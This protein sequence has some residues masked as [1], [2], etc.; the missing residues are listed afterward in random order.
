MEKLGQYYL[1]AHLQ[2][3]KVE[4]MENLGQYLGQYYLRAHLQY[5]KVKEMENLGQYWENF[6]VLQAVN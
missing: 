3:E 1:R 6:D 4:Q 2:Y 5:E